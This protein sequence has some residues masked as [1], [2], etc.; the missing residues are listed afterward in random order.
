MINRNVRAKSNDLK[1]VKAE[2]VKLLLKVISI[3]R[4][5]QRYTEE[6]GD[7]GGVQRTLHFSDKTK[8]QLK[9]LAEKNYKSLSFDGYEGTLP[10]W[11]EPR[12]QAGEAVNITD[13]KYSERNGRYLIEGVSIKFDASNGFLR[14][15]KLGLKI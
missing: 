4:D 11:G 10:C 1:F 15:N 12:T 6:F 3:N 9:E 7:S 13:S 2:D 5:G 14:E 8:A